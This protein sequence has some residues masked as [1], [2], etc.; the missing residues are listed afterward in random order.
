MGRLTFLS[1]GPANSRPPPSTPN[2]SETEYFASGATG[3][4]DVRPTTVTV[5]AV[6]SA[7][8]PMGVLTSYGAFDLE[9]GNCQGMLLAKGNFPQEPDHYFDRVK[10][11]YIREH[12]DHSS[13]VAGSLYKATFSNSRVVYFLFG[14]KDVGTTPEGVSQRYVVSYKPDGT[15]MATV[16]ATV[17]PPYSGITYP[18]WCRAVSFSDRG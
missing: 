7:A 13:N 16:I 3:G 10:L 4:W 11:A 1:E 2:Y 5:D 14:N 8:N 17:A 18:S 12:Q 9:V 6:G 15:K